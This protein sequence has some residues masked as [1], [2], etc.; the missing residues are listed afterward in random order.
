V[1]AAS[2]IGK[3]DLLVVD[4]AVLEPAPPPLVYGSVGVTRPL[5]GQQDRTYYPR[6]GE[7]IYAEGGYGQV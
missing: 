2:I 4:W 5:M 7:L 3:R 1:S 6:Q